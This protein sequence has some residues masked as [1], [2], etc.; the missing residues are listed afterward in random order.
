MYG[1]RTMFLVVLMAGL[2]MVVGFALAGEIGLI[3]MAVL[4]LG[5]NLY[6]YYN[7]HSMVPKMM[8]GRLVTAAEAPDL[9]RIVERAAC[10][11]KMPFQKALLEQFTVEHLEA[12][13]T[14]HCRP[15]DCPRHMPSVFVIET[16]IPNAFATGRDPRH[17]AVAATTG[18]MGIL[19]QRELSGVHG[20]RDR[21]RDESRHLVVH[22]CG[23]DGD[24]DLIHRHAGAVDAGHGVPVR[25]NGRTGR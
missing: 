6:S 2:L 17:S 4:A 10:Q 5:I 21:S 8:G 18:I 25:R 11:A 1:L 9:Y 22:D 24:G 15:G 13:C 20:A 19:T 7:S 3:V 16:P 14:G 12:R 23:I